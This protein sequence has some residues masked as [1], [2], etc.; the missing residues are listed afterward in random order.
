MRDTPLLDYQRDDL[1]ALQKTLDEMRYGLGV[2]ERGLML[3]QFDYDEELI[4]A[5]ANG[6]GG[7]VVSWFEPLGDDEVL[8]FRAYNFA[9]EQDAYDAVE[10]LRL[11]LKQMVI[12][13]VEFFD[14]LDAGKQ[15]HRDGAIQLRAESV[16]EE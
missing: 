11:A 15:P 7:A 3:T 2:G 9:T 4:I 6:E 16:S 1:R 10:W 14:L 12:S 8:L 13:R 5:K